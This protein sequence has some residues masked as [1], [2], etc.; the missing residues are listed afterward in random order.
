MKNEKDF[1]TKPLQCCI[2]RHDREKI[3]RLAKAE[4]RSLSNMVSELIRRA[5]EPP[6]IILRAPE[7]KGDK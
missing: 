3:E 4:N 6:K 1:K 7:P 2:D 5:P